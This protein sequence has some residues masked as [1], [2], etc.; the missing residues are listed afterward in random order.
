[1][2]RGTSA[3]KD[4]GEPSKL[5]VIPHLN[6]SVKDNIRLCDVI[7]P[8]EKFEADPVNYLVNL[9]GST[10]CDRSKSD[11]IDVHLHG[12]LGMPEFSDMSM[13]NEL[14]KKLEY[15]A[16]TSHLD[17]SNT[18]LKFSAGCELHEALGPAFS[19]GYLYF[20][21]ETE[22]TEARN[23]VEVPEGL[24]ISQMTFDTGPDNLL[25]AVVG[26]VCYSSSDVK[27]EK[28]ICKSVQSQLTTEKIS[29]PSSRPK[30]I[31]HSA[32]YSINQQSVVEEYTQNCSSSTGVCAAMSPRGF[33]STCPTV[34]V[35]LPV[36]VLLLN[37]QMYQKR[38]DASNYEKGSSWAVEMLCEECSHFLE[39]AEAIRSLGLTILKGITEV[40]GEKLWICFMV[41]W[42]KAFRISLTTI[43]RRLQAF[44][45]FLVYH[46]DL[47]EAAAAADITGFR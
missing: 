24:S 16:G 15:Q 21:C 20:D 14:E 45:A 18:F 30:H 12:M 31:I 2:W 1:M 7:L 27:S 35:L 25:E 3:W 47:Q 4:P 23:I 9:L 8:N 22:N 26:K 37:L 41:E 46:W 40:H 32:G 33:S 28:S 29:E 10:V 5:D 42:N 6:N 36:Y 39:I 38:T 11:G 43:T 17:T 13:K 19:K 44:N 34:I